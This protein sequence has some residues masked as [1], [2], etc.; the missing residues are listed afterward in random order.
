MNQYK[1]DKRAV[2]SYIR[3][4]LEIQQIYLKELIKNK[5]PYPHRKIVR[6]FCQSI[7]DSEM[8]ELI[9][10][11]LCDYSELIFVPLSLSYSDPLS[12]SCPDYYQNNINFAKSRLYK[13]EQEYALNRAKNYV[14]NGDI[15]YGYPGTYWLSLI[16]K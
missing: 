3:Q 10:E 8:E 14:G 11:S 7:V 9:Q 13:L 16:T 6:K 15:K 5:K 4:N 2:F 1:S 12:S